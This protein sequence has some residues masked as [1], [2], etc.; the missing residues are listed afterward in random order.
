[1]IRIRTKLLV[2]L[3]I[4]VVLLNGVAY[5]L[6]Q[7][8]KQS[9]N[10]YNRILNRLYLLNEISQKTDDVY[11]RLNAYL[12]EQTPE[13]YQPYL[14][15]RLALKEQQSRLR[16]IENK[17]NYLTIENY[18]NM[19]TS[20]LE[21]GAIV[22]GAFQEGKI[23]QYAT[24]L[25]Q[26][27]N[28][29]Q[30]IRETTLE[31]LNE[32]L[33]RYQA[34]YRDVNQKSAYFQSMGIFVFITTF[35][36]CALFV[37]WFSRGI[38][39]PI[40]RLITVA[41]E[42][43]KGKFD[44]K[45]VEISTKDEFRFLT[46]TFNDMRANIH[47]LVEEVKQKSELDRLLKEMEL[48]SL[49]N[50]INPHFLF[51]ILNTVSRTAYLEGANR[52]N[53]LIESTASLLRH[54]LSNLD[55]PTTLGK[56]VDIVRDYFFLQK[57][58]FGDRIEFVTEMEESCLSV[59]VPNMTLQP[60]VENAF[61]HGIES[62]EE[63]GKIKLSIKWKKSDV[64]VEITDNGAGMEDEIKNRLLRDEEKEEG[65]TEG[66]GH[67]TGIGVRNVI[68]RLQLFYQQDGLFDIE[69]AVGQGTT[70]T[71]KLPSKSKGEK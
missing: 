59:S 51:N 17:D 25:S 48:K 32:E 16:M 55:R 1:M 2:F 33:T 5:F 39:R 8:S 63:G 26:A 31:L 65:I 52:T 3:M 15:A 14:D 29:A 36:L 69:S 21:K 57:A 60:I 24:H 70:V 67:S 56:E 71:L 46:N 35:L 12:V 62:I 30:F 7:N 41:K 42:I 54:N 22:S 44:G 66:H 4:L 45:P 11:D 34:F 53:E 68:K 50:Q 23:N 64:I 10:E 49:Q 37:I 19:I 28:I 20:F 18:D 38:T 43:S 6:Y 58:R 40:G 13:Y 9:I 27:E 61:I 47:R